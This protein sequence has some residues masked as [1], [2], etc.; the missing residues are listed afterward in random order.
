MVPIP[1][2][3]EDGPAAYYLKPSQ[4]FSITAHSENPEEAARFISFF[5][6]SIEA[7][8]IL[9]AERGVPIAAPVRNALAEEVDPIT[10]LTFDFISAVAEGASPVPPPDPAGHQ[11]IMNNV[12]EVKVID[13]FAF[14]EITAEKAAEIL[15]QEATAIL[16]EN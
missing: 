9:M 16:K 5:T 1:R 15:R 4:F 14:G 2:L 8:Q 10:K 11:Q 13:P 7:N 3:R 6:N 12:Y